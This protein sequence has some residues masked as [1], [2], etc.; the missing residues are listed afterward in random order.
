[1]KNRQLSSRR[2][3]IAM[4][5][6]FPT[7]GHAPIGGVETA[8]WSLCEELKGRDDI[9]LYIVG[10]STADVAKDSPTN[11][12]QLKQGRGFSGWLRTFHRDVPRALRQIAPDVVHIQ[13]VPSLAA[14]TRHSVLTVHG[15][16]AADIWHTRVGPSRYL[17]ALA[18]YLLEGLPLLFARHRITL[19]PGSRGT[20]IPNAISPLFAPSGERDEFRL[21]TCGEL[22]PLKNTLGVIEAFARVRSRFPHATLTV[23]GD[24]DIRYVRH[25]RERVHDLE[26]DGAVDLVGRLDPDKVASTF[27]TARCLVHFSNRENAPM[28]LV[29]ALASGCDVIA[30]N[31]GNS[32]R[33]LAEDANSYVVP[34]GDRDA[35]ADAMLHVLSVDY[36]PVDRTA[37]VAPYSRTAVA[38]QTVRLYREVA[39]RRA[40]QLP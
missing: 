39:V 28:V 14:R 34:P 37:L 9:D 8:T 7:V 11:L 15:A 30:T 24:G 33:I 31:V 17:G 21:V 18:A 13:G 20:F 16:L 10:I 32:R 12:I 2:L 36:R 23:I 4:V 6:P 40:Q 1:M 29:E 25:L 27:S 3:R 22:S 5:G 26:L 19:S 35:L 38:D